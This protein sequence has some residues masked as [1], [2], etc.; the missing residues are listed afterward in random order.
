MAQVLVAVLLCTASLAPFAS[1]RVHALL[2]EADQVRS[3]DPL[4]FSR[5]LGELDQAR[6]TATR[7]QLEKLRF[8]HAYADIYAGRCNEGVREATQLIESGRDA[9]VKARSSALIVNCYGLSREFIQGL[10]ELERLSILAAR[11]SKDETRQHALYA[12]ASLYNQVGQYQLGLREV[13][14]LLETTGE[15]SPRDRCFSEQL[16]LDLLERLGKLPSDE[17]PVRRLIE[18][19]TALNEPMVAS[20]GRIVLAHQRLAVGQPAKARAA[21][22]GHLPE[23]ESTRYPR[24]ISG[25]HALLAELAL[26]EGSLELAESHAGKAISSGTSNR[27]ILPLVRANKVLYEVAQRRGDLAN[28]FKHYRAFAEADKAYLNEVKTRELAYQ[29]VRQETQQKNQQI[30]LLKGQ[31][32]VLRLQQRVERQATQNSRLMVALLALLV[33]SV[34]YWAYKIKRMHVSL[35]RFAETD[36]LTGLCNRHHFTLQAEKSIARCAKAGEPVALVMFDLD[37]FK[38]I[39][40]NYGHVTG[41]W[42]LKQVADTCKAFCRSIDHIGRLGGE[43]FAIL[44]HGCD[45]EAATRLAEDC[46]VR[47]TQ[48]DSRDSG[49]AFRVTASFG[50]S[51]ASLSG[52]DLARLLSHADQMLYR[53]KRDGRNCVRGYVIDTAFAPLPDTSPLRGDDIAPGKALRG[54]RT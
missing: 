32:E 40:D 25:V 31:N 16:R 18:Q 45:L 17:A 13:D 38:S 14:K 20:F 2:Q 39:N 37:H 44:L 49:H 15:L 26:A 54:L 19:C 7:D 53:A 5:L 30:E 42:V 28:A 51:A 10:R 46:R 27:G 29:I 6:G 47:L 9:D 23:I 4:R 3:G 43:E 34:G 48:I 21:L 12:A 33:A 11:A 41:D 22:Q 35:R 24:L 50:V 1:P 36:A 8:L 52:Y